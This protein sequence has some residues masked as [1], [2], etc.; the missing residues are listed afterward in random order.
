M[1]VAA[2]EYLVVDVSAGYGQTYPVTYYDTLPLP[3]TD[4]SYKTDKIV[5][6]KI[7]AGTFVM[8]SPTNEV[9]R[10]INEDLHQ[11]TLTQ[12]YY[13]G[14]YE[15]TEYQWSKVTSLPGS[16]KYPVKN[17]HYVNQLQ[18]QFLSQINSGSDLGAMSIDLPTEAQWEYACRAGTSTPYSFGSDVNQLQ[19]YAWYFGYDGSVH[20][21]GLKN[22]NP[23]GLYDMH[24]NAAEFCRDAYVAVLGTGSVTDPEFP[25]TTSFKVTKSGGYSRPASEC[26]SAYRNSVGTGGGTLVGFRICVT[27]PPPPPTYNLMVNNGSGDGSYTNAHIQTIIADSAP[28]WHEFERWTGDTNTVADVNAPMTTVTIAGA[29]LTVTATYKALTYT[30]SVSKGTSSVN[31]ATNA[32]VVTIYADPPAAT[33]VF[34]GWDGDIATVADIAAPTTTVTVAGADLNLTALYRN[35]YWLSVTNGAAVVTGRHYEGAVVSIQADAP[36]AIHD[37]LWQ[38]DTATVADINSWNTTLVMPASDIGIYA[39]YPDK[40][41][42]LVVES[43][44]GGGSY[45]NGTQVNVAAGSNPTELHLFDG[46]AG[47]VAGLASVTNPSTVF[48]IAGTN[49]F[50]AARFKPVAATRGE[51]LVVDMLHSSSA[52][53]LTYMDALPAGGWNST[54]KDRYMAFKRIMPG[55]FQMGA[56]DSGA[57]PNENIHTVT[58]TEAFY[59]GV[60]E[61]T[62]GQW[63][64]VMGTYPSNYSSSDRDLHPVENISFDL[65]RGN[66][67]GREWPATADVNADS[68]VGRMR[69]MGSSDG[70]DLPTEAQWEY[71]CRAGTTGGWATNG[72]A[73]PHIAVYSYNSGSNTWSVGSKNSNGWGLYDMHGNVFEFCLD[74]FTGSGL[75]IAP[76]TDPVGA[77]APLTSGPVNNQYNRIIRGGYYDAAGTYMKSGFRAGYI[78]YGSLGRFGFRMSKRI[79][80]PRVLTVVDGKVNS[81]GHYFYRAQI[82]ISAVDK[83]GEEFDCWSVEPATV[84]PGSRFD[85]KNRD[86]VI[87]MPNHSITVRANYK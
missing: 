1:C 45:T 61:V 70:F 54:H 13:V 37:F 59:I 22:P 78:T 67:E 39:T 62:Q 56:D 76:V 47:D 50:I 83:T 3:V 11:V 82:A 43:G 8:G 52:Y 10:S 28:A 55:V 26:R 14:V 86:T 18:N 53:K 20:E 16:T 31:S 79:G 77:P 48:T 81:G 57:V 41:F 23:W 72:A 27:L 87:T 35:T 6:K 9:G 25:G 21:V 36:D 5:L 73:L 17:V 40:R 65:I 29:A 68:F 42:L 58:L 2:D 24:G 64:N 34:Y 69:V 46:W 38:G 75:G 80:V 84:F 15:I 60:F 33:N 51:Y 19:N 49:A 30:I 71:A 66:P 85:S 44:S 7:S 4:N 32:Q 12:D 63:E 74:W